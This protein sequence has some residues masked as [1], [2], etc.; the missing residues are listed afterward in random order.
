M[1]AQAVAAYGVGLMGLIV[2]KILAPGFYA[3][4]DIR[5][6][7]KIAMGVMLATQA[8]NLIF[9]PSW[10]MHMGHAG[11]AL[12][13]GLGACLNAGFLYSGLRKR[14]I[15]Q[16]EAG[17]TKFILRLLIALGL[18]GLL[19]W[20]ANQRIDWLSM[21]G[22][23]MLRLGYLGALILAC[24]ATYFSALFA[25]GFRMKDFRKTVR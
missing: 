25:L 14:G 16:P 17:W 13:V 20:Y 8:M 11:L 3:K 21:H 6:P 24:M 15:Y 19:A 4:Q 1:T 5:T 23:S 9:V 18:M 2:V 10:G 22:H 7:V 12:S